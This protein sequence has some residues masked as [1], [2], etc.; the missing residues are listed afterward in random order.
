MGRWYEEI[1]TKSLTWMDGKECKVTQGDP[2]WF[3]EKFK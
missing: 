1:N 3:L 2:I